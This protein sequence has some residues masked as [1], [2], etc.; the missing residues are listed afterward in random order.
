MTV[1]ERVQATRPAVVA[2]VET[3]SAPG[4]QWE[5][6]QSALAPLGYTFVWSPSISDL[7]SAGCQ[8]FGNGLAVLG[9]A[10]NPVAVTYEAQRVSWTAPY[11]ELRNI[12]CTT[13][14]AP[15]GQQLTACVTH[16]VN[17]TSGDAS[18]TEA[19]AAEALAAVEALPPGRHIV[20]GDFNLGPTDRA[21]DPWYD[22]HREAD[23]SRRTRKVQPT[24]DSGVKLDYV[25]GDVGSFARSTTAAVEP[26][27]TSDHHWYVGTFP[28][29]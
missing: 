8:Q 25:F 12:A 28:A 26:V 23:A 14:V 13:F 19:Q 2:V 6:L 16:L 20:A 3:C 17:R 4:G 18:T 21:L 7:G 27:A 11:Q 10:S 9:V 29:A 22:G 5:H 15:D 24:H 1:V